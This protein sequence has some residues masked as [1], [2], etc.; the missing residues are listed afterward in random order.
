ME[1]NAL[2]RQAEAALRAGRAGEA[3]ALFRQF[4]TR[5]PADG[6]ALHGLGLALA[7]QGRPAEALAALDAA[8]RA[9]PDH[10]AIAF[11]RAL[12]RQLA[13]D[14]E[15]AIAGFR[16]AAALAPANAAAWRNLGAALLAADAPAAEALPAFEAALRADP[17]D[18]AA[19]QGLGFCRQ[20]LGQAEAALAAF[21]AAF[22]LT[23]RD[24]R[25]LGNLAGALL[26]AGRATDCF[27]LLAERGAAGRSADLATTQAEAAL[28]LGR[29]EDA[30][31]LLEAALAREPGHSRAL[32]HLQVALAG[33][34]DTARLA[35]S[36]D[37]DRL[38]A[39]RVLP[40]PPAFQDR[41]GFHA[42]LLAEVL[43]G[44][45]L[46]AGREGKTTRG[47]RQSGDLARRPGPALAAL[48]GALGEAA[49]AYLAQ[50][51]PPW[52]PAAPPAWRLALWATL[53]DAGGHQEPH[54]H[55]SGLVSGVYYLA[56][57]DAAGAGEL[58]L[59]R[60]PGHLLAPGCLSGPAL[61]P[62]AGDLVLFP[63]WLWHRTSPTAAA[64]TRI[65]LAFDA[66]PAR[67][68]AG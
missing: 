57:P 38:I 4:L 24:P 7:Q 5:R 45:G 54:N 59:G 3:Q 36:L 60:P 63:S 10:P 25:A 56:T 55:P 62:R 1:P 49:A 37:Y 2:L 48:L 68:R 64:T 33:A 46:V 35:P 51:L 20:R 53:L 61:H 15:G 22:A 26:A 21:Q 50:P 11:N 65:S 9:L 34:G 44:P 32:G 27:G 43:A 52:R 6:D 30:V 58:L 17:R 13:G 47:G 39:R 67:S 66:V 18:A 12:A 29:P 28:L 16:Q 19:L 42:A 23:P 14:G 40:V 31:A 41:A 8:A